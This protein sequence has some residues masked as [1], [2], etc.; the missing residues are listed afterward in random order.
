[1]RHLAA[2]TCTTCITWP[3][4]PPC[5]DP[6]RPWPTTGTAWACSR[7]PPRT[8]WRHLSRRSD[9]ALRR[10]PAPPLP[11]HPQV[12]NPRR[13]AYPISRRL[14]RETNDVICI[15][16]DGLPLK[17]PADDR[18]PPDRCS[19]NVDPP[20]RWA[21]PVDL[22]SLGAEGASNPVDP[23]GHVPGDLKS[24]ALPRAKIGRSNPIS[25]VATLPPATRGRCVVEIDFIQNVD[26]YS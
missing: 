13:F 6:P 3:V 21:W 7:C 5:A 10:L 11:G 2:T 22:I 25:C 16:V 9:A 24:R 12:T 4:R 18:L 8:P 20:G 23:A 14:L 17:A 15:A 1:M 26:E 19:W